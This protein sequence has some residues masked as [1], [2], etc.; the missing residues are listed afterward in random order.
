MK[1]K[2]AFLFF[3]LLVLLL[4][5]FLVTYQKNDYLFFSGADQNPNGITFVL[6]GRTGKVIGW[7]M[8]P[9]LTDTIMVVDYRPNIGVV[10]LISLPR[11]LYVNLDGENFKLNEVVERGKVDDFLNNL[12]PELT[13]LQTN[14]YAIVDIGLLQ[15][16]VDNLG[17]IDVDLKS[18]LTDW[19]SGYTIQAGNQHLDGTQVVWLVR[20]RY[21]PNGDFFREKNQHQIIQTIAQKI[22]GLNALEKTAFLFKLTPDLATSINTNMNPQIFITLMEKFHSVRFNDVVMDFGSGLLESATTT[23]GSSTE[24]ILLPVKGSDN[25]DNIR[26]YI[27]SK[28]EK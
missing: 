2:I 12:L 1:K 5:F 18:P 8:S 7:N 23:A 11:D 17:G 9:D 10:N 6:F 21:A 27:E 20:N 22:E 13:G 25:Y 14:N 24:D 15:K 16:I 3:I 19:A 28:L 26:N 4:G